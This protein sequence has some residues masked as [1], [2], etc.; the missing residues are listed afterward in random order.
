MSSAYRM[1]GGGPISVGAS[2]LRHSSGHR[3]PI[4]HDRSAQNDAALDLPSGFTLE[5]A[6]SAEHFSI[7]QFLLSI[8]HKPTEK[9]FTSAIDEPSYLPGDR[10]LIKDRDKIVAHVLTRKR[11][12]RW[13]SIG[14]PTGQINEL[15]AL[16][17]YRGMGLASILLRAAERKVFQEGAILAVTSTALPAF[18]QPFGWG[19]YV[20][21][22]TSS[23][24]LRPL[25][26]ELIETPVPPESP[27]LPKVVKPQ[28]LIR[29]WRQIELDSIRSLYSKE[30][31][32]KVFGAW[33]RSEEY[34]RWL[35]EQRKFDRI[36]VATHQPIQRRRT[37]KPTRGRPKIDSD[38]IQ[39]AEVL[40]YAVQRGDQVL[41]IVARD[42][43]VSYCKALIA[44]ICSDLLEQGFHDLTLHAPANN[45][46]HAWFNA[47]GRTTQQLDNLNGRFLM[48][49]V[50]DVLGILESIQPL[51][52]TRVAQ[53]AGE[54]WRLALR[55]GTQMAVL[56][57]KEGVIRV[58]ASGSTRN[59]VEM[60]HPAFL[61]LICGQAN[62]TQALAAGTAR[63]ST[64]L[65]GKLLVPLFP[66]I[67]F[68]WQMWDR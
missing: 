31:A 18:F 42:G 9:E 11:T 39:P 47:A 66:E 41:E 67:P 60:S 1:R 44:R 65:A 27:F 59:Y 64:K 45:A 29:P 35:I 46:A 8:F 34:W 7:R 48:G 26:R 51:L 32:A 40:A 62:V 20:P 37:T 38:S 6:K 57:S 54:S 30:Y 5:P 13:G 23:V 55:V 10:L 19:P 43:N 61:R 17:E 16:P 50:L 3:F 33:D 24:A 15:A 4:A 22:T 36:Y 14:M 12:M 25:L 28:I 58:S 21:Y 68:M 56:N 53:G 52:E 63:A 2:A 49:K